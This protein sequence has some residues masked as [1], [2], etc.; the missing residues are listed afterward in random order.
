M[1]QRCMKR[2]G[3]RSAPGSRSFCLGSTSPLSRPRPPANVYYI[4][5]YQFVEMLFRAYYVCVQG[6]PEHRALACPWRP[7]R[8]SLLCAVANAHPETMHESV[9][10]CCYSYYYLRSVGKSSV[11]AVTLG[12][13]GKRSNSS[14]RAQTAT[15]TPISPDCSS[16]QL[17]SAHM[18]SGS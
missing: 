15:S 16:D 18:S 4:G 8:R 12:P 13:R 11:A 3:H 5:K 1:S 2:S 14:R 6:L 7:H 9:D 17:S 10:R